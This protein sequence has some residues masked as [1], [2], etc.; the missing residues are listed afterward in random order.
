MRDSLFVP[1]PPAGDSSNR[2]PTTRFVQAIASTVVTGALTAA[3][4]ITDFL[5]GIVA[6]PTNQDYRIVERI[7]VGATL[8]NLAG[9]TSTGSLTVTLKVNATAVTGGAL[10]VTSSQGTTALTAAN[11][12]TTGDAMVLTISAS[13]APANFSFTIV[14]TRALS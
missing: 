2:I 9:K 10:N 5:S 1:D 4:L 11:T 8:T 6:T 13:T 7:P 14:F 12:M 3:S